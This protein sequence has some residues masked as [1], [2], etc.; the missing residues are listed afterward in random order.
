MENEAL[1]RFFEIVVGQHGAWLLQADDGLF[2]MTEDQSRNSYLPLY[3]TEQEAKEA[4]VDEWAAY[5]PERMDLREL[6]NWLGDLKDDGMK[7]GVALN[8]QGKL[9]PFEAEQLQEILITLKKMKA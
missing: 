5:L 7:V 3:A 6:I 2:A 9:L 8:N 4:A 1:E